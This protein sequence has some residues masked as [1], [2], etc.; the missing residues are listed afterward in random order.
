VCGFAAWFDPEGGRPE[1]VPRRA[2][3]YTPPPRAA[4]ALAR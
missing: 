2:V 1:R 4:V 3:S